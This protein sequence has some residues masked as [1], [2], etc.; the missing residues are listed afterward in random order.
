MSDIFEAIADPNRRQLLQF[1]VAE[2]Q[3]GAGGEL[4]VSELVAKSK[5]GQPTVSKHLRVLRE[6]ELVSV[7][8]V[9]QKS[10]YSVTP[11]ALSEVQLWLSEFLP[12]PH[13]GPIPEWLS[14][15]LAVAGGW[16]SSR[17]QLETDP[18]EL[19]LA[20]GRRL[21]DARHEAATSTKDFASLAKSRIDE[22]VADLRSDGPD[23]GIPR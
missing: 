13:G 11:A 19:G 14:S 12:D 7:R 9:G 17:V 5:L 3:S 21:A 8:Q 4:S 6:S 1:L 23:E 22:F 16:V 2:L 10:M 18:R 15:R 20:L